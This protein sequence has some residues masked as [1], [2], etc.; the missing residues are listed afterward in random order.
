[1]FYVVSF[2]GC[3]MESPLESRS[4]IAA[5]ALAEEAERHGCE[6]VVVQVPG[7]EVLPVRQFAVQ[8]C[9]PAKAYGTA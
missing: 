4:A 1:M 8:Y 7:G 3:G 5:L 2:D 9:G 6:N